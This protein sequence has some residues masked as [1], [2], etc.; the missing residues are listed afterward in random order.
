MQNIAREII[1]QIATWRR[2]VIAL[3]DE[4]YMAPAAY[5]DGSGSATPDGSS[6]L[7]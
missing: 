5:S 7:S 6:T 3:R 2:C 4:T 1:E